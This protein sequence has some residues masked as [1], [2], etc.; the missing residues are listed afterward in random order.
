V[1]TTTARWCALSA[2]RGEIITIANNPFYR[3]RFWRKLRREA[4][5]RDKY[6]CTIPACI[7]PATVADHIVARPRHLTEPCPADR[8][9]NLRSLC[10]THDKQIKEAPSGKRG[11]RGRAVI[12]GC[13]ADGWPLGRNI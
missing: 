2:N 1:R 7:E 11:R 9:E 4:L 13:D 12:K 3:S 8:L 5:E 6:R 10:G